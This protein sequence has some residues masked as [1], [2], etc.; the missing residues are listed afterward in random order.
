MGPLWAELQVPEECQA[1]AWQQA[2]NLE[3]E[4]LLVKQLEE[5]ARS[6]LAFR[7]ATILVINGLLERERLVE[8]ADH[9]STAQNSEAL[10]QLGRVDAALMQFISTWGRRFAQPPWLP[11]P[12]R[13]V[14]PLAPA[15][16]IWRGADALLLLKAGG[17]NTPQAPVAASPGRNVAPSSLA[18]P[19][20]LSA[21]AGA[22]GSIGAVNSFLG[23]PGRRLRGGPQ[24]CAGRAALNDAR[25]L[26]A[27]LRS[28][29]APSQ[30]NS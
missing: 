25:G 13:E 30:E 17:A 2:S 15:R 4:G 6:M 3:Q 5:L 26:R 11:A 23:P 1:P 9:T 10:M 19:R 20:S 21:G 18:T 16:F 28:T 27:M 24:H 29:P 22:P 12:T 8:L 14:A 7:D